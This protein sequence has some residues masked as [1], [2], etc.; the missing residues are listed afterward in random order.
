MRRAVALLLLLVTPLA[1]Q[2][3]AEAPIPLQQAFVA[4]RYPHDPGAFT[5]GLF[6]DAGHLFEST[7]M[8]GRSSVRQ[9]DLKTGKVLRKVTLSSPYFGEGI[10]PWKGQILS[11]TWQNGV[12]FRWDSKSLK[13]LGNFRYTG[14]GWALTSTGK[15]LVMSDG[16]DTLRFID[17]A[18]F[19]VKR[20]LKVTIQGRPLRLINEL[21][22][23]DGQ[24]FANVWMTDYVVRI[25]PSSGKVVGLIDLGPLHRAAGVFGHDRV[26]NGIAWDAKSRKLYMTGKE[27]PSLFEVRLGD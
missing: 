12:G 25:D 26:A 22:W 24:V 21:E 27:W 1:A 9:V 11:L 4:K 13:K 2:P 16:S 10:A 15:E 3:A 17:P 6:I 23:V 14:E 19:T 8:I 20:T 7:G 5:E 18:D